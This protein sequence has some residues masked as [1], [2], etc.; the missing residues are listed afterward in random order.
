MKTRVVFMGTPD[1][2]VPALSALLASTG[3]HSTERTSTDAVFEVVGV[4]TQPDRGSGR[5]R[6]LTPPPIKVLAQAHGIPLF[7]PETLRAPEAWDAIALLA[8]DFLVVVAY[9]ELLSPRYLALPTIAPINVHASL[10]PKFRGAAPIHW[11]IARGEAETG[12][13]IMRMDRGLDSGPVYRM[14][15]M[16]IEANDTAGSLHDRLSTLGARLLVET[17]PLI[18]SGALVPSEQDHSKAT[19]APMLKKSDGFLRFDQAAERVSQHARGMTPWPGVTCLFK[20]KR[21]K[22]L[23]VSLAARMGGLGDPGQILAVDERGLVIACK[24]GA[25]A[26]AAL[27]LEGKSRQS[28]ADFGRGYDPVVAHLQ[29]IESSP[30]EMV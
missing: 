23:E 11:S 6:K 28:A 1:F 21:L 15:S 9:G 5:G 30:P 27:Q 18:A 3:V 12:V 2:A 8:P 4:V 10:L 25:V 17:L 14:A 19:L 22:L 26:A 20:E 13:S 29:T 16:V 7:Q 24:A